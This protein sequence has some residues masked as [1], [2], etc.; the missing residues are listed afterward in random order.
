MPSRGAG[1]LYA[2]LL[3]FGFFGAAQAQPTLSLRVAGQP[4]MV[5]PARDMQCAGKGV[6]GIDVPDMPPTAFKRAD[7]VVLLLAGNRFNYPNAGS[8]LDEVKR[9][10]CGPLLAS[11]RSAE[12]ASFTD[13]EWLV[14]LYSANGTDVLGL[15][16]NEYHGEEHG[17]KECAITSQRDRECWYAATTLVLSKDGGKTFTR[18]RAPQNV[19]AALP[20]KFYSGMKRAG[21][22]NAK[23]VGHPKDGQVYVF[24]TNIERNRARPTGEC[25]VRADPAK[26]LSWHAWDGKGFGQPIGSAYAAQRAGDCVQVIRGP[27]TSVR[28]L[29]RVKTF[30]ALQ[31]IGSKL[32]YRTSGDLLKW[33]EPSE[34]PFKFAALGSYKLGEPQP[35]EY[36]SLL[37]P[38]SS[39]RNFDTLENRPYLY[40]V[41]WHT[42]EKGVVNSRRDVMRVRLTIE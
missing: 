4:E 15:V 6:P 36:F 30:V 23:V 31:L 5:I 17:L 2:L 13:A 35:L 24:V 28:Y 25:L 29:P 37:D 7:G 26:P 33:S 1:P 34:L 39:S 21:T 19:V 20:Y 22:S 11:T 41:R 10:D 42:N 3:L 27:V 14:A 38:S 40:F 16:H 32:Q 8:T 12:P 18:P 9:R